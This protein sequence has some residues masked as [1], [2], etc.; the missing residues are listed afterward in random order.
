M[1]DV[2]FDASTTTNTLI[3]LHW[4]ALTGTAAGGSNVPITSYVIEWD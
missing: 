3:S 4:N 1:D 2:W